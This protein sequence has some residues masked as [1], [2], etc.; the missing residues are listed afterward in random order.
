MKILERELDTAF[1]NPE[2]DRQ[3]AKNINFI[4]L[5]YRKRYNPKA[6]RHTCYEES[7]RFVKYV[8]DHYW[9]IYLDLKNKGLDVIEGY[10]EIDRPEKLPLDLQDLDSYEYNEFLDTFEEEIDI[11]NKVEL[12][13]AIW[14]YLKQKA[15][16]N[17][18]AKDRLEDFYFF[19]H[20]WVEVG[21]LIIDFTVGQFINT[22][23]QDKDILQRYNY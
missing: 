14:L 19:D 10:F 4:L 7:S 1:I 15:E 9:D 8:R 23:E 20:A 16:E 13:E 12:S 11:K 2:D 21:A 17:E 3:L 5:E 6:E 22:L 18:E